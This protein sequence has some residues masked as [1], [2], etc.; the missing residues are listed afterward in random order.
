MKYILNLTF[1]ILFC[2]GIIGCSSAS[3]ENY[4]KICKTWEGADINNLIMAW[5]T[6]SDEYTMPNGNKMYTWLDVQGSR[7]T[8]GYNEWLK[9]AYANK[10]TYWCK[11]EFTTDKKGTI[12]SWRW[13]GNNCRAEDPDEK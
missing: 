7:V 12:I 9:M 8:A 1:I 5:G 10:V 2:Y 4:S 13:E 3:T 6:P 11:T